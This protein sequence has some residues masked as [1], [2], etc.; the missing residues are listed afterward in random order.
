MNTRTECISPFLNVTFKCLCQVFHYWLSNP[1][2]CTVSINMVRNCEMF[3]LIGHMCSP[4]N[5]TF[6]DGSKLLQYW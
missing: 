4:L 2:L 1:F 5:V 6:L 3:F